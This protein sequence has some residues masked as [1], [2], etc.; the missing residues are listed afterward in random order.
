M[1]KARMGHPSMAGDNRADRHHIDCGVAFA[2]HG[3][4][5]EM[6]LVPVAGELTEDRGL[7]IE[8]F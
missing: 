3:A 1:S 7:R 5:C 2:A 8:D 6:A 4:F